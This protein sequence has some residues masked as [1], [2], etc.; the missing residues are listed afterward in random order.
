MLAEDKVTEIC[1][2]I[3]DLINRINATWL[4][5]DP[6]DLEKFF[7]PDI[8]VQ[9]P[10]SAPRVHGREACI[11]SYKAFNEQ[12]HVKSFAPRDAEIDVFGDTIVATYRYEIVY[13][14]DGQTYDEDAGELL[15]FLK[16]ADSWQVVWRTMVP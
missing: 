7:H 6:N 3:R 12:T 13:E 2:D 10:G 1:H 5:G 8:V 11:A 15:V 16:D 4:Q 9:P 14:T